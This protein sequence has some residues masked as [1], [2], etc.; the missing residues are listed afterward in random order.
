M[1]SAPRTVVETVPTFSIAPSDPVWDMIETVAP[2]EKLPMRRRILLIGAAG[3]I[4]WLVLVGL[5]ATQA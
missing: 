1:A 2:G 3:A 4:P 5:V